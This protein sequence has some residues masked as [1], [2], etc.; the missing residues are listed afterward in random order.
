MV[1]FF[2]ARRARRVAFVPGPVL[3]LWVELPD[4]LTARLGRVKEN[5]CGFVPASSGRPEWLAHR[6]LADVRATDTASGLLLQGRILEI[7]GTLAGHDAAV[8]GP[9]QPPWLPAVLKAMGER[10]RRIPLSELARISRLHP[11]HL[12]RAFKQH[13]GCSIG[14]YSRQSRVSR[15]RA[16][17]VATTLSLAD[18]A[19]EC[20]FADQAHFSREFK[21]LAGSTPLRFRRETASR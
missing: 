19:A 7:L 13:M 9:S 18:I 10:A 11:A 3:F 5:V 8:E 17:L 2:P 20:E 1:G 12:S 15:A 14:E 16:L 6:L 21:R 4:V